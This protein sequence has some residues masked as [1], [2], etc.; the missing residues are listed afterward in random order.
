MVLFVFLVILNGFIG[1]SPKSYTKEP[2]GALWS[3][4]A[5]SGSR[6]YVSRQTYEAIWTASVSPKSNTKEPW[7]ATCHILNAIGP[8]RARWHAF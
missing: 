2:W 1:F 5:M 8:R 6:E 4:E 3:Y 7:N